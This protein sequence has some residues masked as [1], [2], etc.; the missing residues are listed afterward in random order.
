MASELPPQR[1]AVEPAPVRRRVFWAAL[2]AAVVF[3]A[4][5]GLGLSALV[6]GTNRRGP[7]GPPG[8]AGIA[9]A[10]GRAGPAGPRGPR[11]PRGAPGRSVNNASVVRAISKNPAAVARAIQPHLSPDPATLCSDLQAV[12]SLAHAK[13]PC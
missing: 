4:A 7:A 9:G 13:L 8:P 11:G 12:K 6:L 5:G 3:G 10:P 1:A 2:L